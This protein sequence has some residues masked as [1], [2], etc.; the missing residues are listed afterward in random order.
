MNNRSSNRR[1]GLL[2]IAAPALLIAGLALLP[3]FNKP[4]TIDDVTFLLQ[5]QHMLKDPLHPTAFVMV[6]HGE[7]VRLSSGLVS[8]PVMAT[9][10][11]PT[12]LHG[13]A[14]WIAH[15][16]Q[17]AMLIL[18]VLATASLA[19]R[20]GLGRVQAG[21][22]TLLVCCSPAVLGMAATSMPDVPAMSF[23]ALAIER[24]L[25]FRQSRR[26]TAGASAALALALAM[27]ARPHLILLLGVGALFLIDDRRWKAGI[28]RWPGAIFTWAMAPI[29]G[30][31]ALF[32][33]VTFLTRDPVA[34]HH[35][36]GTT[37]S[38]MHFAR[39]PFNVVSFLSQWVVMFPLAIPWMV[40]HRERFFRQRRNQVVLIFALALCVVLTPGGWRSWLPLFM[41]AVA[42]GSAVLIDILG[43]AWRRQDRTQLALG[44]WLLLA[45]PTAFYEHLPPKYLIASAPAMAILLARALG[46]EDA[47][48]AA[49]PAPEIAQAAELS[50]SD[51]EGLRTAAISDW[52]WLTVGASAAVGLILSILILRADAALAEIGR[53]GGEIA[54]AEVKKGGTV[55]MDGDWGF[56]WYSM[57]AGARPMT[58]GGE[59]PR[60]GDVVVVSLGGGRI[61]QCAHRTLLA[62]ERF[63]GPGGRVLGEGAGFYS[64]GFGPLP[65]SWGS[66]EVGRIEVWRIEP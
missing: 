35:S 60:P 27:L 49:E 26:I 6:F 57:Q 61:E 5:A 47:T 65:W 1:Q 25:C 59:L 11:L 32:L 17:L 7:P 19:L 51:G 24:L 53:R 37:L 58:T 8:G 40:L 29:F 31:L 54:A 21:L 48:D 39:V 22:A 52:S 20:L 42:L 33:G 13:G 63:G 3:F 43:E 34:G 15:L 28:R 50:Q 41:P 9:L 66:G 2:G 4:F 62:S 38:R 45:L 44:L 64:N 55:W 16:T 10:L 12:V 30:S 23:G 36:V 56:Q 46:R 14:E 18:G